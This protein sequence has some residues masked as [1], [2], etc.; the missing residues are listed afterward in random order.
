MPQQR[1][2]VILHCEIFSYWC[3]LLCNQCKK[4]TGAANN[5]NKMMRGKKTTT[6]T[7]N[8][9]KHK[10][11]FTNNMYISI[12]TSPIHLSTRLSSKLSK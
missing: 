1:V 5:N 3:D 10:I 4:T 7:T 12:K 9:N 6:M 8:I 2:I 11:I